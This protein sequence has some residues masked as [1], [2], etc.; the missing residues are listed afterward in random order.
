V[1][2]G[3]TGG[4]GEPPEHP[5]G[6]V[7]EG[8]AYGESVPG[9]NGGAEGDHAVDRPG[10]RGVM[11]K[12]FSQAEADGEIGAVDGGGWTGTG[13]AAEPLPAE[14]RTRSQDAKPASLDVGT[15]R[16][17]AVRLDDRI[18]PGHDS[19]RRRSIQGGMSGCAHGLIAF[20]G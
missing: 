7:G 11:S 16:P 20:P 8:S 13:Q 2:V 3:E 1:L 9:P 4:V 6:H 19:E 12:S 17:V 18:G 14:C 15:S 10:D 5:L